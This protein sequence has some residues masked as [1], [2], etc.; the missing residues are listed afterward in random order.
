MKSLPPC[1][2]AEEALTRICQ[3]RDNHIFKGLA[4]LCRP[5]MTLD[6]AAPLA[7]DVVQRIGTRGF[8]GDVARGLCLRLSPQI[9]SSAHL[10]ALLEVAVGEADYEDGAYLSGVLDL[11]VD[12]SKI[13]PSLFSHLGAKVGPC[14]F[15]SVTVSFR[16]YHARRWPTWYLKRALLLIATGGAGCSSLPSGPK[17]L[18]Q[19][20]FGLPLQCTIH[21]SDTGCC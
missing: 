15:L 10:S 20:T 18:L 9:I 16:S 12:T 11:L 1:L 13:S 14:R 17:M 7:K 5:S 21:F 4:S 8:V 2:Q 19:Q 3:L 6:A